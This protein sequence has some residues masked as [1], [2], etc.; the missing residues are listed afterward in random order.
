M[1]GLCNECKSNRN[2][3]QCKKATEEDSVD[4]EE[5]E[6]GGWVEVM[7]L[8]CFGKISAESWHALEFC[9]FQQTQPIPEDVQTNPNKS[10]NSQKFVALIPTDPGSLLSLSHCRH[11]LE[12]WSN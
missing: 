8:Y 6:N 10:K 12:I 5:V 11:F 9:R 4:E 7:E 2:A 1:Y 3:N